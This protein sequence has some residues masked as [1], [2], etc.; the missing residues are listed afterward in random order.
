MERSP[1]CVGLPVWLQLLIRNEHEWALEDDFMA[2]E[3]HVR[4]NPVLSF[5]FVGEA[6]RA[7]YLVFR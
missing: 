1:I 6:I 5:A 7:S 2:D 3:N 4:R